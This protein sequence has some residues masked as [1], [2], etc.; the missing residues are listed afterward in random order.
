MGDGFLIEFSSAVDSVDC[1][2]TWQEKIQEK[3]YSLKFRIGI[4]LGDVIE[5]DDDMYGDGVNI[6]A[7]IEKLADPG[8]ICSSRS[9]FDQVIEKVN[10][11]LE[12]LGEQKVKNISKPVGVYKLLTNPGDTGKVIGEEKAVVIKK[13]VIAFS[14]LALIVSISFQY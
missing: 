1:A 11:G 5:Q 10:L 2:I 3:E 9:I 7:Q 13:P 8:G 14:E 4:N 12:Y 6:A